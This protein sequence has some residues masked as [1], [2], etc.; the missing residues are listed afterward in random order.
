MDLFSIVI[1]T[2]PA[3][4]DLSRLTICP[5]TPQS[6][7]VGAFHVRRSSFSYHRLPEHRLLLSVL[8][9]DGTSFEVKIAVT[10]TVAELKMA[11]EDVFRD[12]TE[13]DGG[14]ISWTHVWG[15]FCLSYDDYKLVDDKACL[16]DYGIKDCDQLRF[17]RHLQVTS[18]TKKLLR[19]TGPEEGTEIRG[20]NH[21]NKVEDVSPSSSQ[22]E[23]CG[24]IDACKKEDKENMAAANREFRL[25][26][27]FRTWLSYS[28][29][30]EKSP[31]PGKYF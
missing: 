3:P 24:L 20:D 25:A 26:D 28:K 19:L 5:S 15:H 27:F 13:E 29:R 31:K 9:L 16:K 30:S 2:A 7:G 23:Q 11:V 10:A 21:N 1:G 22:G 12:H 14:K 8:K 4:D 6:V 17:V 18:S